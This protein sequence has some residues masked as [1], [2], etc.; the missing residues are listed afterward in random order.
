MTRFSLLYGVGLAIGIGLAVSPAT[1]GNRDFTLIND[2]RSII[3]QVAVSTSDDNKWHPTNGFKPLK[4]GDSVTISFDVNDKSSACTL[5]LKIHL[6]NSGA[7]I[8]W[9]DGFNFCQLHKIKVWYNY[10]HDAYSVTYY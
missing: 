3:D 10:D 1:A 4:P 5:Q 2:T 6:Q 7:S 9:D 8:E